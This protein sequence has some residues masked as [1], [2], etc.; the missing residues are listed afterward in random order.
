MRF[1]QNEEETAAETTECAE[2][3]ENCTADAATEECKEGDDNCTPAETTEC[4]EGEEN[5]PVEGEEGEA[6]EEEEERGKFEPGGKPWR[7]H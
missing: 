5:C 3:D 7:P 2:G 4:A 6:A 1:L